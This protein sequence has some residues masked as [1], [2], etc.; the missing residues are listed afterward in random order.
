LAPVS[1][2]IFDLGKVIVD[3]SHLEMAAA[4]AEKSTEA[5]FQ[6]PFTLLSSVF[7]SDNALTRPFDEGKLSPQEFYEAACRRFH[8]NLSYDDFILRWNRSFKENARVTE[9]IERLYS[10]YRLFLLSNTN[11]LHYAYL[12]KTLPALQKM[13]QKILSFEIGHRKPSPLIFQVALQRAGVPPPEILYIDDM[14]ESVSV[15]NGLGIQGIVFK[16]I[17]HLE[18]ELKN[19]QII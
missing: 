13:E 2:I 19:R 10:R 5:R 16:S 6:N 17:E 9:L 3:L 1:L 4:I 18:E 12:E 7:E 11:L 8:L 15:A 14:P